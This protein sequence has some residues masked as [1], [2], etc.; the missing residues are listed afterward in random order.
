MEKYIRASFEVIE[1]GEDNILTE[2]VITPQFIEG[3]DLTQNLGDD[4]RNW[5]SSWDNYTNP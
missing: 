2:S 1:F 4:S 5:D 3:N